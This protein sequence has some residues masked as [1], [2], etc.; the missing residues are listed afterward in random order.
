V[1]LFPYTTLF[2]STFAGRRSLFESYR[3]R[4]WFD[5]RNQRS[6]F[7]QL[8]TP[9]AVRGWLEMTSNDIKLLFAYNAWA[10]NR[11]FESLAGL[12][13]EQYRRDLGSSHGGIHG[14]VTHLLGAEAMW[15]SRWLGAP[16]PALLSASEVPSLES[17]KTLWERVAADTAKFV[18]KLSKES[19]EA[20]FQ[21]ANTKGERFSHPLVQALQHLVNHSTYHRGQISGMMRQVGAQPVNTDLITFYRH[22]KPASKPH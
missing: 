15:L 1:T 11:I 7:S 6:I 22:L 14:A 2:R 12:S 17:L 4:R 5:L 10:N 16:D 9:A 19:L 21:Y 8:L 20:D 18:G 13:E 3:Q